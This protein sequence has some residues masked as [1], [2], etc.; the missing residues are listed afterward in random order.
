MFTVSLTEKQVSLFAKACRDVGGTV[1][2][3]DSFHNCVNAREFLPIF[4]LRHDLPLVVS[5]E[6]GTREDLL[7]SL[8]TLFGIDSYE[9]ESQDYEQEITR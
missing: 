1:V 3:S 4:S 6:S 8:L 7:I 2:I 9:V 5:A